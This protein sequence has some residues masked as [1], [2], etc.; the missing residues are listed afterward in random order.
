MRRTASLP[1]PETVIP[2]T[3]RLT[4]TLLLLTAGTSLLAASACT[5]I[6]ATRGNLVEPER[7]ARIE[8]G[9]TSREEV[10]NILGT[11]TATGTLD[12][13]TWYYVGRRTEQLAFFQPDVVEQKIVRIR[14]E[15]DGRVETVEE[16]DRSE[17]RAID[18]VERTT[19]T[20]GREIGFFEQ[21]FG[22]VNRSRSSGDGPS[23]GR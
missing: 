12:P 20:A 21:L 14:F 15:F 5:P 16:I 8:V 19:P 23:G 2:S 3:M 7:L 6:V 4:R 13:N 18:P 1:A 9:K 11:P 17:A 10:Q 22:T